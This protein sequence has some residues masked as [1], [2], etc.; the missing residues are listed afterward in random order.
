MAAS[1]LAMEF[2]LNLMGMACSMGLVPQS[3]RHFTNELVLI[4]MAVHDWP[5][6]GWH[7]HGDLG[8]LIHFLLQRVGLQDLVCVGTEGWDVETKDSACTNSVVASP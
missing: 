7:A 1:M 6:K 5:G 2:A 3:H 8:R 4:G